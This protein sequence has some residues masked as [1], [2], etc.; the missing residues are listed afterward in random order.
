MEN[1]RTVSRGEA[2]EGFF[3]EGY[4]CAQAVAL[5]F[6]DLIGLEKEKT[7]ALASSFGGGFGRSREV[8]GTVSG[9][10]IVLGVCFGAYAPDDHGAKSAHYALVRDFMARFAEKNGSYICRE[11][12]GT[13]EKGGEPAPRDGSFYHKRPCAAIV[14]S[15]AEIVEDI[16]REKGVLPDKAD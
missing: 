13:S 16:L 5:A 2:A 1:D 3:K 4:N 8:C 11:L 14:R 15:A 6:S 12:L 9:G 7:A 10:C